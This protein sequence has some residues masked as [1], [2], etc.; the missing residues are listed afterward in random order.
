[1]FAVLLKE[2]IS[3]NSSLISNKSLAVLQLS[4]I[5]SCSKI[6]YFFIFHF[7]KNTE[8]QRAFVNFSVYDC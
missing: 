1:M 8:K 3:I 2:E 5:L 6:E 7:Y 4:R